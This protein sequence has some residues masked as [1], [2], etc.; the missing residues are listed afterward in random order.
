LE[1]KAWIG[2]TTQASAARTL[3]YALIY[4]DR[5]F[6]AAWE[7]ASLQWG[8]FGEVPA[9]IA[10]LEVA[11]L[12]ACDLAARAGRRN[13]QTLARIATLRAKATGK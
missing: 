4:P 7:A 13:K 6:D 1:S 3:M 8:L 10:L 9:K 12:E 5:D 11:L 2:T